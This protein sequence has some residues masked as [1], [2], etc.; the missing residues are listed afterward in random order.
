MKINR[1]VRNHQGFSLVELI[2]VIVLL[3]ILAV[4]VGSRFVGSQGF[5][6]LAYQSKLVSSLR[7]MQTRAM[8][9]TRPG[10]CFLVNFVQS[11]PAFGPPSLQYNTNNSSASCTNNIDYSRA[12]SVATTLTEMSEQQVVISAVKDG[13]MAITS[14]GFDN[15]GRPLTS[16]NNC[17]SGCRIE[18]TGEQVVAVCVA[19][20]GFIYACP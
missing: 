16:A 3:G 13:T 18:L 1:F 8:H 9:D 17:V 19:V 10:F 15:L 4:S 14:I 20:Q 11:P 2:I 6:E 12:D 7:A 5:A